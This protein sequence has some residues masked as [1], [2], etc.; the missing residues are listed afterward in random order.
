MSQTEYFDVVDHQGYPTGKTVPRALAH[1]EGI[2]HRT[3]HVWVLNQKDGKPY[4]LLQRRGK[5]KDSFPDTYDTSSAGHIPA[6]D[7]PIQSACRE[8]QEELGITA[9]PNELSFMGNFEIHTDTIF[10][11]KPFKD[12]EFDFAYLY[13][14]PVNEI[15]VQKEELE[16]A[17]WFYL[18]DV[19]DALQL[20]HPKYVIPLPSICTLLR[21]LVTHPS[22]I[23]ENLYR[24]QVV[25]AAIHMFLQNNDTTKGV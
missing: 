21:Y 4:V 3:A 13:T 10:H 6:G 11:G 16:F 5:H 15:I 18:L 2:R 24:Q 7:I 1:A 25:L 20:H 12:N 8:L 19:L 17:E 22:L 9:T 23:S 14:K